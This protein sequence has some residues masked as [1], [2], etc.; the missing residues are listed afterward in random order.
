[1]EARASHVPSNC[2][3]TRLPQPQPH[4]QPYFLSYQDNPC[5]VLLLLQLL[6]LCFL[7]WLLLLLF[8]P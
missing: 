3:T 1:M 2:S 7:C 6:L 5:L 4:P 8:L